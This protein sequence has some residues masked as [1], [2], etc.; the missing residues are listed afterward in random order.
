MLRSSDLVADGFEGAFKLIGEGAAFLAQGL[1][2]TLQ[3]RVFGVFGGVAESFL[4]V[5]AEMGK[6]GND[7]MVVGLACSVLPFIWLRF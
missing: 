4:A 2:E 6:F 5:A 1:K 7:V 3:L